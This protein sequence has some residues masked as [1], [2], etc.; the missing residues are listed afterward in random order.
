MQKNAFRLQKFSWEIKPRAIWAKRS[1]ASC[2]HP[3]LGPKSL[4]PRCWT[5]TCRN[6]T[7]N[8]CCF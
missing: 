4:L 8:E 6:T 1:T 3:Q 2:T 5:Y 7:E